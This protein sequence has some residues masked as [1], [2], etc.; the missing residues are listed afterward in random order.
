MES[1]NSPFGLIVPN[2]L[3]SINRAT[4]LQVISAIMSFF[5]CALRVLITFLTR[6]IS[7]ASSSLFAGCHPAI[8]SFM[9]DVI[10]RFLQKIP[11][12][13]AYIKYFSYLCT[14]LKKSALSAM[15]ASRKSTVW[16]YSYSTSAHLLYVI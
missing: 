13:F 5:F 14:R 2:I 10:R 3:H 16:R 4:V 7:S 6:S 9:S 12:I 15:S 1:I 8:L 11:P